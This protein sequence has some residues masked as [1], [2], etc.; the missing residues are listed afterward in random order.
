MKTKRQEPNDII[1]EIVGRNDYCAL[2][3]IDGG[4]K[5]Q[6]HA[7]DPGEAQEIADQISDALLP[8][9]D[10]FSADIISSPETF[11]AYSY[12]LAEVRVTRRRI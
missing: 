6:F 5:V 8:T 12:V 11:E 10:V 9:H 1:R 4:V 7:K 3:A 2:F